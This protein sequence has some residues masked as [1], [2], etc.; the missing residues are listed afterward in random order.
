MMPVSQNSLHMFDNSSFSVSGRT[1]LHRRRLANSAMH[2]LRSLFALAQ[3]VLS[4]HPVGVR[5]LP[6]TG[7]TTPA[8]VAPDERTT[9][10]LGRLSVLDILGPLLCSIY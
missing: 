4:S 7:G 6:V 9:F 2:G 5:P 1:R 3:T 8:N 10:V